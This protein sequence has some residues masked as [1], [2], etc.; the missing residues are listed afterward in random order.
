MK[1]IRTILLALL[2][3]CVCTVAQAQQ[4]VCTK[5]GCYTVQSAER[6]V[7]SIL[8]SILPDIE[9]C[10]PVADACEPAANV[11]DPVSHVCTPSGC[12]NCAK[13]KTRF[14]MPRFARRPMPLFWR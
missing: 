12:V 4:R 10:A 1:P 14:A 13:V 3:C 7:Q 9:V 5:Y 6:R 8:P 2:I 11:C